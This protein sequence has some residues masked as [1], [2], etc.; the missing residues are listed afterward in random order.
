MDSM[1]IRELKKARKQ[2][3]LRENLNKDCEAKGRFNG[4]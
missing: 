1:V 4:L 3:V 2:T